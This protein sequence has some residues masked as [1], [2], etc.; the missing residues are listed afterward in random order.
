MR[1]LSGAR[2]RSLSRAGAR[3]LNLSPSLPSSFPPSPSL[4]P[5]VSLTQTLFLALSHPP[6]R[7]H[8]RTHARA[9]ARAAHT[10][11]HLRRKCPFSS[12]I[13]P[14]II[15]LP[16]CVCERECE[17]VC[18]RERERERESTTRTHYLALSRGSAVFLKNSIFQISKKFNFS[19]VFLKN[20]IFQIL[21]NSIFQMFLT[22]RTAVF[23]RCCEVA[24]AFLRRDSRSNVSFSRCGAAL[25]FE[26]SLV[27]GVSTL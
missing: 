6:T 19:N 4:P 20:S 11:T 23:S 27:L 21:K 1:R 15:S 22:T 14:D 17:C 8:A 9:R 10:H 25:Y 13:D 26:L 3:S 16:T 2:A 12:R 18:V 24:R 5:S 7:T